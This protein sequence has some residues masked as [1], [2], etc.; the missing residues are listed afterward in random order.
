MDGVSTGSYLPP[1]TSVRELE[2]RR[3]AWWMAI[4]FDRIV[5]IGGWLH[6]IDEQDI[7][8]ELPLRSIDFELEARC[9]S[10]SAN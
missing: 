8:T 10:T 5:S 9:H 2:C 1:P 4:M 3:R 7:G 6:G